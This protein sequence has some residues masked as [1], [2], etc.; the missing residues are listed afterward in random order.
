MAIVSLKW[1]SL[2]DP[3][4]Q[5]SFQDATGAAPVVPVP[6]FSSATTTS[7][8]AAITG[9]DAQF[10]Y[11]VSASVGTATRTGGN[12]TVSGLSGNQSSTLTIT[13][14]NTARELSFSSAVAFLSLP[15]PPTLSQ[16]GQTTSSVTVTIGNYDAGLTYT[17]GSSAGSA[18]RS[19]GI[20]TVTGLSEGQTITVTATASNASGNSSQGS[21]SATSLFPLPEGGTITTSGGYRIHT[22]TASGTFTTYDTRNIEYLVIAGG[23][24]GG[25]GGGGAGG[26]LTGTL[27]SVSPGSITV[28]V[29][30]GGAGR[31]VSGNQGVQG[32]DSTFSSIAATKG[33]P[34]AA[35]SQNGPSG[36]WGSGGGGGLTGGV[37]S[38]G[39][40]GQGNNGGARTSSSNYGG[41]GGAG[42]AG[43]TNGASR[44]GDGL[45][46]SI[47]G[48]SVYRAGGGGGGTSNALPQGQGGLGGGA[49][50]VFDGGGQPAQANT[51]G[52]GGGSWGN[53]GAGSAGGSG[54]VVVRYLV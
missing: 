38:S 18:T 24:G 23:G 17:V 4:K 3:N 5:P 35:T 12:V 16:T 6:T 54:V 20:I 19:A 8:T 27:N 39:T 46:S 36:T 21:V 50:G 1:A 49:N 29:G 22:F 41:G 13:A 28:T 42:Q 25:S 53:S 33:G 52:G 37:G 15:A 44:G 51:G 45:Q 2:G 26:Y 10:T 47:T 31:T 7:Y 14:A 34:G 30:A 43:N 32:N 48:S 9:F 40:A 11:T